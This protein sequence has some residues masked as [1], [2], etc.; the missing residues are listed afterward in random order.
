MPKKKAET[1]VNAQVTKSAIRKEWLSALGDE[2]LE[3]TPVGETKSGVIPSGFEGLDWV[4]MRSGGAPRGRVTQLYGEPGGGKSLLLMRYIAMAQ[5]LYPD[6]F[7]A[8]VD[9]EYTFDREWAIV[10][11][12]DVDRLLFKQTHILEEAFDFL[13]KAVNTGHCSLAGID[14]VGQLQP[15]GRSWD[16]MI[17]KTNKHDKFAV[18]DKGNRVVAVQPGVDAK[19]IT[20]AMKDMAGK[21]ARKNTAFIAVNQ[22]RDKIGVMYGPTR[23]SPGGKL[24]KHDLSIDCYVGPCKPVLDKAKQLIAYTVRV[25]VERNKYNGATGATDDVTTPTFYLDGGIEKSLAVGVLDKAARAGILVK[26][27]AWLKLIDPR[28][29]EIV[30]QWQGRPKAEVEVMNDLD[31][32][33]EIEELIRIA[34]EYA[35]SEPGNDSEVPDTSDEDTE[36]SELSE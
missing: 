34:P 30:R 35:D 17:G 28:S 6:E 2:G 8:L 27:A 24:W 12:V 1:T 29:G 13:L 16:T 25:N 19:A 22:V 23:T 4:V 26:A 21:V 15:T 9:T 7:V 14:S 31:L 32:R 10:N 3:F 11:G 36:M 20:E 5:R 33:T 18:D